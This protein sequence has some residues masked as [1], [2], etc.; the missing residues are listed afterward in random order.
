MIVAWFASAIAAIA[1]TTGTIQGRVFNPASKEYVRNAEVRLD[2]TQQVVFTEG[3][4]SFQFLNVPA[5]NARITVT[6]LGYNTLDETLV[7][8]AGQ[9][10]VR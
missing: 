1:Q 7:V 5:G 2:A 6:F 10:A 4:G 9:T 3:D 8:T